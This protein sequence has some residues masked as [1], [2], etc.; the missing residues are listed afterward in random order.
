M[1]R[2]GRALFIAV[3]G[4]GLSII[5]F[6]LSRSFLLSHARGSGLFDMVS[7]V[8]RSTLLQCSRRASAGRCGGELDLL[9]SSNEIGAF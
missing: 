8:I 4:F 2:A 6:G 1:K 3:A 5:G 7:V 9:R